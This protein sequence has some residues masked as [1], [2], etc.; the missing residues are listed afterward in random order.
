M[1]RLS[2]AGFSLIEL[3]IGVA[4]TGLAATSILAIMTLGEQGIRTLDRSERRE[5]LQNQLVA[6]INNP[7][8]WQATTFAT[9]N[10]AV[11]AC[12]RDRTQ[13]PRQWS[14]P[15]AAFALFAA[16]SPGQ[17]DRLVIDPRVAGAGFNRAGESCSTYSAQKHDPNCATRVELAWRAVC[18]GCFPQQIEVR[19]T[20]VESREVGPVQN[21]ATLT[22][23]RALDLPPCASGFAPHPDNPAR[24]GEIRIVFSGLQTYGRCGHNYGGLD[25]CW[26]ATPAW[27][28]SSAN[29][30]YYS[31]VEFGR[32]ITGYNCPTDSA[33][34]HLRSRCGKPAAL[35]T[36]EFARLRGWDLDAP[37]PRCIPASSG[38]GLST[39]CLP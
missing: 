3:L 33:W 10:K 22:L 12:V 38:A 16:G 30:C 34:W 20:I 21:L 24:C 1:R 5:T 23:I 35:T 25:R 8:S 19:V 2:Q 14:A 27:F 18:D 28:A 7:S 29:W 11:F 36:T 4:A 37:G 15:G 26:S 17:P 39:S 6:L 9:S 32:C 13:C 31:V